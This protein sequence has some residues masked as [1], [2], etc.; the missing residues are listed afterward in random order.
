[1]IGDTKFQISIGEFKEFDKVEG[2]LKKS[3]LIL[4]M[5][6]LN[7]TETL[8]YIYDQFLTKSFFKD[9]NEIE[10]L[11][12]ILGNYEGKNQDL[13]SIDNIIHMVKTSEAKAQYVEIGGKDKKE[14]VD[15]LDNFLQ[16]I[17]KNESKFS[18]KGSKADKADSFSNCIIY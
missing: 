15:L 9:E 14:I 10:G 12:Y 16:E 6:D 7:K 18:K 4:L 13:T 5:F 11:V 3:Q 8:D 2:F 1:M 17:K